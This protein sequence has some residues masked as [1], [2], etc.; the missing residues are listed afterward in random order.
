M[1]I[2]NIK[3]TKLLGVALKRFRKND[4]MSQQQLA[5]KTGL[6]QATISE[7][8]NGKGTID[9]L[10]KIIQYLDINIALN[11]KSKESK[12]LSTFFQG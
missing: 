4:G 12:K 10:F 2:E 8:E 6:R 7:L 3:T 9:S 11:E 5:E 1:K